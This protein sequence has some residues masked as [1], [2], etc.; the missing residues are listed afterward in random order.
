L[1]FNQETFTLPKVVNT[2]KALK[3]GGIKIKTIVVDGLNLENCSKADLDCFKA[4]I[5]AEQLVAWFSYTNESGLLAE[6][7][8]ADKLEDFTSV[9]HI[10]PNGGNLYLGLLKNG[11]GKVYLDTKTLLMTNK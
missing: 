4:F 6:T 5:E 1:N 3:E 7:L 8:A 10:F 11:D 2:I 9:A